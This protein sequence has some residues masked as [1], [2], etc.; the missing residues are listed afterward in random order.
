MESVDNSTKGTFDASIVENPSDRSASSQG[1]DRRSPV[2]YKRCGDDQENMS[3]GYFITKLNKKL[4]DANQNKFNYLN[5][6]W[7]LAYICGYFYIL[8][9]QRETSNAFQV[10]E[11]LKGAFFDEKTLTVNWYDG[12]ITRIMNSYDHIWYVQG[13]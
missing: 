8:E 4:A 12:E 2:L 6:F 1:P 7:F 3:S 5:V 10:E 13:P 11:A 9:L